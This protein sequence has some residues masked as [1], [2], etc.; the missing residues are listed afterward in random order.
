MQVN[1]ISIQR[2]TQ[3]GGLAI[4]QSN[5][6]SDAT[7]E[8]LERH[9]QGAIGR[10]ITIVEKDQEQCHRVED[11]ELRRDFIMRMF[12]MATAAFIC[13]LLIVAGTWLMLTDH[14]VTGASAVIVAFITVIGSIAAGGKI[15]AKPPRQE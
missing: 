9:S 1:E 4:R 8:L 2:V 13:I 14:Y 11:A 3:E 15:A 12:G 10:L 7:M 5:W 6:P